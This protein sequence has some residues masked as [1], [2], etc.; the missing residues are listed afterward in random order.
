MNR[1][2]VPITQLGRRMPTAGRL[3]AGRKGRKGQ[4][5]KLTVWRAT[6]HDRQAI[7]QIAA[8]YGG[9]PQPWQ[10]PGVAA[11][12]W[13]VTTE[14]SE[15]PIVLPPDPLG[16]SP[17]YEL[18]SGG[19]CQRRCD[20]VTCS[21]VVAGPDGGEPGEVDCLCAAK[22][23]LECQVV[24]RLNVLLP[25][26]RFGGAWRVDTHSW[27]AARELPGMVDMVQQLQDAAGGMPRGVIAL[28]SRKSTSGG[29]TR[30][31]VVPV[32]RTGYSPDQI[33]SGHATVGALD[34]PASDTAGAL[35]AGSAPATP[36]E[37]PPADAGELV[38]E[39]AGDTPTPDADPDV[40]DAEVVDDGQPVDL[41]AVAGGKARLL[42]V[43]RQVA[44]THQIDPLP[45][46][47]DDV[48]AAADHDPDYR[49]DLA[50]A[51][52]V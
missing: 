38:D 19:G 1:A 28:E 33:T 42:R 3:R 48:L 9:T 32:I 34:G 51:L 29:Q 8:R 2:P 49:R 7:E 5:E 40:E 16:G 18:W 27:H 36:S 12:Q 17:I 4:P 6:S 20:G 13:E 24:T 31:F 26:V 23:V 25:E 50:A 43:G 37:E 52:E 14:A 35:G 46:S 22:G 11:G 10:D 30:Q 21:T 45:R 15:L 39:P 47:H 41:V 44:G